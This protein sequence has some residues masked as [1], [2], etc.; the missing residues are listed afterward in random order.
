MTEANG[1]PCR[2]ASATEVVVAG[3]GM[4]CSAGSLSCSVLI[5][6]ISIFLLVTAS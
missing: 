2:M 1:L 5:Y 4:T 3:Y 6:I